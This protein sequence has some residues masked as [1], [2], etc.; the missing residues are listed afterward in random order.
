MVMTVEN[1]ADP[2]AIYISDVFIER[3]IIGVGSIIWPIPRYDFAHIFRSLQ[4]SIDQSFPQ[5][6]HHFIYNA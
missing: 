6:P 4:N 1:M 3:C 5:E 2:I